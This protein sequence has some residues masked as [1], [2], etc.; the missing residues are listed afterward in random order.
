MQIT[1]KNEQK[2]RACL[3]KDLSFDFIKKFVHFSP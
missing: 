3:K 1:L 2:E